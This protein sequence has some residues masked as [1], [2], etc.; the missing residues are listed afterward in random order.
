MR[1]VDRFKLGDIVMLSVPFD[2]KHLKFS[3][4]RKYYRIGKEYFYPNKR[5]VIIAYSQNCA[6]SLT[7][8]HKDCAIGISDKGDIYFIGNNNSWR[9]VGHSDVPLA[10]T[11]ALNKI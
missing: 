2:V 6:F 1:I 8:L 11:E 7:N 4:E 3:A 5:A 9:V 10:I